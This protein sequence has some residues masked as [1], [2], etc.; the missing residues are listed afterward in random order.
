MLTGIIVTLLLLLALVFFALTRRGRKTAVTLQIALTWLW[1]TRVSVLAL[2]AFFAFPLL[3]QGMGR[4]LLIAAYDLNGER[5]GLIGT[6]CV[7]L[8]L[9]FGIWTVFVTA[10]LTLS[11]GQQRTREQDEPPANLRLPL[12]FVLFAALLLNFWTAFA[13]TD[14]SDRR[15]VG[16]T[17]GAGMIVGLAAIWCIEEIHRQI[18]FFSMGRYHL[19]PHKRERPRRRQQPNDTAFFNN[20]PLDKKTRERLRGYVGWK[21]N[22][23]YL[24]PGHG[25]ALLAAAMFGLLIYLPLNFF[26]NPASRLTALTYLLVSFIFWVWVLAGAT[27]FFDAYR[28]PVLLPLLAWLSITPLFPKADHFYRIWPAP[29]TNAEPA[30]LTPAQVLGRAH[31]NGR[32][33]VL[34]AAA[35]GGIQSAAWTA[36]V[37]AGLEREVGRREPGGFAGSVQALSGVSGGSTGI[38]FFTQAYGPNGFAGPGE[39]PRG[40]DSALLDQIPAAAYSTSLGQTTWGLAYPDLGR[41]F[42]PFYVRDPFRDRAEA[43]E[44]AWVFNARAAMGDAGKSLRDASLRDWQNDTRSS[45]RPAVIFNSTIV[46]TGERMR[47]S[48]APSQPD[49][50]RCEFGVAP[51]A[52]ASGKEAKLYLY[53]GADIRITTAVRLSATFPFVLPSARPGL[54]SGP[55]EKRLVDSEQMMPEATG[56]LH[57]ADG[58][59]YE[60]SGLSDLAQ[61]LDHGLTTAQSFNR[62]SKV[63][64]LQIEAF[65]E[66]KSEREGNRPESTQAH[67]RLAG[68]S[69][70]QFFAP[71]VTL[72]NVRGAGHTAFA[73]YD[74]RLLRYRWQNDRSPV[75]IRHVRFVLPTVSEEKKH[76]AKGGSWWPKWAEA[77]PEK[78]PLSWHLRGPEQSAIDEA[79]AQL[80][81]EQQGEFKAEPTPEEWENTA[82]R[83]VDKVLYFL[84]AQP[85]PAPSR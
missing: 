4:A 54:A 46:E 28:I 63:L 16:L 64:V 8:L 13:A 71:V 30:P 9:S 41:A 44:L 79:W 82:S 2:L 53:R 66:D 42:F 67:L 52:D 37:L 58:G 22:R 49:E 81:R 3:A 61:W 14:A 55:N 35:G 15:N 5:S 74:F 72:A 57:L 76:A 17:L 47:F 34:V 77:K 26:I 39:A 78:P 43:M 18:N 10:A 6:G 68:G 69:L 38:M 56:N 50:G 40:Y 33:V 23:T 25:L 12:R 48:S 80:L 11:Y 32:K 21:G 51:A 45:R 85:T 31:A 70:F 7:G 60:N 27:F 20:L 84:A 83:P 1:L 19:L 36:K 29:L 59:Y 73:N 65:P 75:T 62:P 24:L